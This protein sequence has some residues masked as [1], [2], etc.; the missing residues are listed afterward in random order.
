VLYIVNISD[1]YEWPRQEPKCLIK[2]RA[3]IGINYEEH[4]TEGNRAKTTYP[5][6]FTRFAN[7][8]VGHQQAIIRPASSEQLDFEGELAV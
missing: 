6:I 2:A 5:I 1:K 3:C 4:R 8:Q 7:T